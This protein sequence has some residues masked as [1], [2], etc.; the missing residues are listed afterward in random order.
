MSQENVEVVRIPLRDRERSRRALDERLSLRFPRLADANARMIS[1]LPP[2]SRL[3]QAVLRR[4]TELSVEAYNR[5]DLQ[6]FAIGCDPAFEYRPARSVVEAGLVEQ[7][8]HG[9]EGHREY[10]ANTAEVW[11]PRSA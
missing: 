10:V 2:R 1:R 8:Y 3:R 7:C 11:G 6:A 9:R 5:R 4:A